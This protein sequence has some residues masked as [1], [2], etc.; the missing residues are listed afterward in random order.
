M[1]RF[2]LTV[3]LNSNS[4]GLVVTGE[5]GGSPDLT[6]N[7]SD[8]PAEIVFQANGGIYFQSDAFQW[9]SDSPTPPANDFGVS[10]PQGQ[11]PTS[12]TVTDNDTDTTQTTYSYY[13]KAYKQS[14]NSE[15]HCDPQ[16]INKM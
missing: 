12:F 5:N 16:I 9:K 8:A 1:S 14:D 10:V 15:V 11:R 3:A 2:N 13:V 6:I 7:K 4:D